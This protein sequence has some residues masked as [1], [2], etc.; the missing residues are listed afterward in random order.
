MLPT[1]NTFFLKLYHYNT[2]WIAVFAHT[3]TIFSMKMSSN[4]ELI[5]FIVHKDFLDNL[6][7]KLQKDTNLFPVNRS[8]KIKEYRGWPTSLFRWVKLSG[9]S[10]FSN[11]VVFTLCLDKKGKFSPVFSHG[12][13]SFP[14]LLLSFPVFPGGYGFSLSFEY[15]C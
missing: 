8:L 2:K 5:F 3:H 4:I 10:S 7:V 13:P 15:L 12:G 1:L 6:K 14:L 9:R 11:S